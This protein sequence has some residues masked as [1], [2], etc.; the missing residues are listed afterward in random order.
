MFSRVLDMIKKR[1]IIFSLVILFFLVVGS[2]ALAQSAGT[3]ATLLVTE[4]HVNVL[5]PQTFLVFTNNSQTTLTT[6]DILAVQQGDVIEVASASSAVLT[7]GDGTSAELFSDTVVQVSELF[8]DATSFRVRLTLLAGK[9]VNRVQRLLKADDD[10]DVRTP[11]STASVR[12]TVFTVHVY[13]KQE[14]FYSVDE[15]VVAVQMGEQEVLVEAGFEV[16]AVTSQPLE[17][18]PQSTSSQTRQ[19][20]E[21]AVEEQTVQPAAQPEPATAPETGDA[22]SPTTAKT[23]DDHGSA[24]HAIEDAP[25]TEATAVDAAQPGITDFGNG[26]ISTETAVSPS[27]FTPTPAPASTNAGQPVP[28]ATPVPPT[29]TSALPTHTSVPSTITREPATTTP[30]PTATHLLPTHTIVPPTATPEPEKVTLCH[31]GKTISVDPS[32]V[33]AHLDHGDTLG[34]CP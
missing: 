24:D 33:Q 4:G 2:Y 21:T 30:A 13:S 15:G 29:A 11:S 26:A 17:T 14:T 34:P 19:E 8:A 7:M 10:Y 25:L 23:S 22:M 31:N 5:Q 9:M 6:G 16:T 32:S 18:Q 27:L 20:M 12:G 3:E 1:I 28:S